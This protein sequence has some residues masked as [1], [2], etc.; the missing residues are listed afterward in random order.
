MPT[1]N[2]NFSK[3]KYLEDAYQFLGEN[4]GKYVSVEQKPKKPKAIREAIEQ[5]NEITHVFGVDISKQSNDTG[6][7]RLTITIDYLETNKDNH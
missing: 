4:I 1:I 3:E 6:E 5:I 2:V 7:N